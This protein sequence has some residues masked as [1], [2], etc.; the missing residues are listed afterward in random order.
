LYDTGEKKLCYDAFKENENIKM[1]LSRLLWV[2]NGAAAL[3]HKPL[4]ALGG[5]TEAGRSLKRPSEL[6]ASSYIK[7]ECV[8]VDAYIQ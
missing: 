2:F 4:W 3:E 1:A 5:E 8:R 6:L 7:R